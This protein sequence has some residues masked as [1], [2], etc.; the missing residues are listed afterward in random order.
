MEISC[1]ATLS[2]ALAQVLCLLPDE[3]PLESAR[4]LLKSLTSSPLTPQVA[5][6]IEEGAFQRRQPT[7]YPA[8]PS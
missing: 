4:A 1:Q 6:Q 2:D 8:L 5:E 7:E 3:E